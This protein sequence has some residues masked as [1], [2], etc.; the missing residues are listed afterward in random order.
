MLRRLSFALALALLPLAL[1]ACASKLPDV[2]AF[3]SKGQI[4]LDVAKVEV[5]DASQT[6]RDGMPP[7]IDHLMD[8]TPA[9][10]ARLWATDTLR[11]SGNTGRVIVTVRE[12][13]ITEIPV[14]QKVGPHSW[15]GRQDGT[16]LN[17]RLVVE[18]I[19]ERPEAG[20]AGRFASTITYAIRLPQSPDAEERAAAETTIKNALLWQLDEKMSA[21]FLQYLSPLVVR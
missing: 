20:F 9:Q 14:P 12:A 3:Q 16:E 18:V 11:A 6:Y 5:A 13:S 1:S 15:F 21:G 8:P 19:G 10:L 2:A 4:F 17:G 7:R